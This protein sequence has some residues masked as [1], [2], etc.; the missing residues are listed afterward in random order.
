MNKKIIIIGAGGHGKV[1]ADIASENGYDNIVFL[2]DNEAINTCGGYPVIGRTSAVE[3]IE[4]DT[5]VA[6]G[7]A[8]IRRRIQESIDEK[9]LVTLIHPD[10]VVAKDTSVGIGTVIMAGAVINP[11]TTVGKGCIINTCSSVD[12]DCNVG[13]FVHISVGTHL[14]GLVTI[15]NEAWI[16]AGATISNNVSICRKSIVGA[17]AVVVENIEEVG[18]Y[19]GI[20]A[21]KKD[22]EHKIVV[23]ERQ[24]V[25]NSR[26]E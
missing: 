11:G 5:I 7:N 24:A 22:S 8:E 4:A 21:R 15:G 16:G 18:T 2:D 17:G 13:D 23:F 25:Q 1:V 19:I 14:C 9:Y 12:H 3:G 6:I 26:V 20:P 10:A